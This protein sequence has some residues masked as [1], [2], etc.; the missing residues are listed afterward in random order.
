MEKPGTLDLKKLGANLVRVLLEKFWNFITFHRLQMP[1]IDEEK[2][3][4]D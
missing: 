1:G 2:H 4:F 3:R